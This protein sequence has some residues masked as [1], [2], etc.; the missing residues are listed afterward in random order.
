M[1][2]MS[3][4]WATTALSDTHP[5]VRQRCSTVFSHPIRCAVRGAVGPGGRVAT[6]PQSDGSGRR[7]SSWANGQQ[8]QPD[9]HSRE[10]REAA[11]EKLIGA[12]LVGTF[13]LELRQTQL[14]ESSAEDCG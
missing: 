13:G 10:R 11:A 2:T 4:T 8:N 3:A 7:Q 14:D 6:E 12:A 1:K 9:Q 5:A